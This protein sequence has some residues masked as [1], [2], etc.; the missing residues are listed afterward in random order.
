MGV[1]FSYFLQAVF[2]FFTSAGPQGFAAVNPAP[3]VNVSNPGT[4][5][6]SLA[7]GDSIFVAFPGQILGDGSFEV[8]DLS[9]ERAAPDI[10]RNCTTFQIGF[11]SSSLAPQAQMVEVRGI[12]LPTASGIEKGYEL[13]SFEFIEASR[14]MA[15][16]FE[17]DAARNSDGFSFYMIASRILPFPLPEGANDSDFKGMFAI[18]FVDSNGASSWFGTPMTAIETLYCGGVQAGNGAEDALRGSGSNSSEAAAI[19]SPA[20]GAAAGAQATSGC[21]F[22]SV[23]GSEFTDY[24]I[25][26][27]F[28]GALLCAGFLRRRLN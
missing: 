24:S 26:W 15:G 7:N 6:P 16:W 5:V 23:R 18:R 9:N 14:V 1:R 10:F 19:A 21:K 25:L 2:L 4:P 28:L 27:L 20:N 3:N 12:L 8:G 13:I 17:A 11:L 22:F